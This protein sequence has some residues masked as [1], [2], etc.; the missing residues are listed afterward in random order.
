MRKTDRQTVRERESTSER[1]REK[2]P[3]RGR[4]ASRLQS[5]RPYIHLNMEVYIPVCILCMRVHVFTAADDNVYLYARE[6]KQKTDRKRKSARERGS[7]LS[8]IYCMEHV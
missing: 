3:K 1:E 7:E 5:V 2:E 4:E 8:P 6:R